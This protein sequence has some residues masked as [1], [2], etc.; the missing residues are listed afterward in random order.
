MAEIVQQGAALCRL[1]RR[2]LSPVRD[3]VRY[4][5]RVARGGEPVEIR[6]VLAEL[7]LAIA[8]LISVEVIPCT[9]P[10]GGRADP[11]LGG[12]SCGPSFRP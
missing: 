11:E 12:C 1:V 5:L 3:P 6:R 2:T 10:P 8:G 4:D 7:P 9:P